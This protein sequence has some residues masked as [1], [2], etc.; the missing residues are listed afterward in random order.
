MHH[1][2]VIPAHHVRAARVRPLLFLALICLFRL[3]A[4]SATRLLVSF[5]A[6]PDISPPPGELL[7]N[8]QAVTPACFPAHVCRQGMYLHIPN[9]T[10]TR[11]REHRHALG[12]SA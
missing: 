9:D 2:P 11:S 3:T 7:S 6:V 4:L 10:T 12:T 1:T 5:T 8:Q